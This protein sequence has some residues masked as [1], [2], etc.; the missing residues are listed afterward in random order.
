MSEAKPAGGALSALLQEN[1][2]FPPSDGFRSQ[3]VAGPEV[4]DEA[5][6]DPLAWWAQQ[7]SQLRWETPWDEILE[8]NIPFARWF[9]GGRLN[10]SVN[11]V[12]R[13]VDAG[14]GDRVAF[15]WIG[16]P[17]G[18][19]RTITYGDLLEMVSRAA[20]A[21]SQIG[22][23]A[24][25]RVA[26]YL[27]MIP[28]AVVAMLA[29]ARL[30]AP[31]SVVFGGFSAEALAGRIL[32]LDARVVITADGG[33]RRG[34][35]SG[36]KVNVDQALKQCPKVERVLVVRRTG[37]EIDW[38]DGRDHLVARPCRKAASVAHARSLRLRAARST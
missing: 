6:A 21:L 5:S 13:H 28:E 18:D 22:V 14:L 10:A 8:W 1:R 30:G 26:I 34:A 3:A 11:C 20:H 2:R 7:A 25:D 16:E 38:Q 15:H 4:Y 32:D 23:N 29:C 37:Q 27:P 35:A 36:L 9:V 12:D 31:H 33:F 17:E 24:G 19:T